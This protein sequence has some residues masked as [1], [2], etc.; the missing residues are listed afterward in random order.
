ML[1]QYTTQECIDIYGKPN[2]EGSYLVSVPVSFPLKLA[3]DLDTHVKTI[4]CHKIEAINITSIFSELFAHYG[5]DKIQELHID[6]FGG[7]FNFRQMRGGSDWSKHSWGIAI[8]LD[9]SRNQ[10]KESKK[11]ARFAREEYKPMIDIFESYGW[12][13]LG[14]L[15]DYDWMH[16]EAMKVKE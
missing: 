14:R 7:C 10:L 15:R 8:D 6:H 12:G 13:S 11:T 16:F 3:W 5:L 2:Q 1:R 9:P 4:R